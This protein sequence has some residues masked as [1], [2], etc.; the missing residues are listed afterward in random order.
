[1][2]TL[3]LQVQVLDGGL[4]GVDQEEEILEEVVMLSLME[5]DSQVDMTVLLCGNTIN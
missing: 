2:T 4:L 3:S 5:N 1:V